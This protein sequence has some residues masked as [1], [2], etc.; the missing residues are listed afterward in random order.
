MFDWLKK[1]LPTVR[2]LWTKWTMVQKLILAGITAVSVTALVLVFAVSSKPAAVPIFN[3]PITNEV[4]RNGIMIRLD[5]EGANATVNAAGLISVPDQDTARRMRDI[6]IREDLVP[7]NVDP[8]DLFDVQRWTTTALTEDVNLR[9]SIEREVKQ[10]VEA[11]DDVDRANV[12]ISMPKKAVFSSQQE[13]ATASIIIYAKPRSDIT[14]NRKKIEGIQKLLVFAV[15]GL[16][17]E[18]ITINDESGLRIN[19]FQ[20]MAANDELDL[21]AKSQKMISDLEKKYRDQVLAA[22]QSTYSQ[23]RVRDLNVKID[24]DYSKKQSEITEYTPII[25][26]PDN[27]NTPYD[28]SQKQ[29]SIPIEIQKTDKKWTGTLYSPEGPAGTAGQVPPNYADMSNTYGT[30]E[31]TGLRQTNAV[32]S[33]KT[34][35]EKKPS[36]DRVT[37]SVNIDGTW[38]KKYDGKGNPMILVDGSIDREY[39]AVLPAE[40]DAAAALVR[41]AIGYNQSRGD[42]VAV[43][44]IPFDRRTQFEKEDFVY[45]RGQQT[46]RT[47]II[48]ILAVIGF[49]ILIFGVNA[50]KKIGDIRRKRKEA[51]EQRRRDVE[52]EARLYGAQE[53]GIDITMSEDDRR[54]AELVGN[55]ESMAR[56]HP[57]NVAQLIRTW[58]MEE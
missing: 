22:L 49:I 26:N 10:H 15:E 27:P 19:D 51:E 57:E 46:R 39:T 35:E 36:I 6:L 31:E 14:T 21:V 18:N 41:N 43:Q 9:R 2:E 47:F 13:P 24:M 38:K 58:M 20:G 8:W 40:L 3:V 53:P 44:N 5:E 11:L 45:I 30:S 28:D 34:Q 29:E 42:S 33:K 12:V 32:N 54:R 23:D 25:I 50:L 7:G 56:E 52:E 48:L 55:V 4:V 1:L 16:K 37:V 17:D